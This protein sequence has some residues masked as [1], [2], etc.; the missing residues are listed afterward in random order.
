[1]LTRKFQNNFT[2][3]VLSPAVSARTDLAKYASGCKRIVNGVVLAHGGIA[4]RNGTSYVGSLPGPG[5][6]IPFT[7]SVTQA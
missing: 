5:R 3:G 2:A 4:F 6:L 1:M 7:Y